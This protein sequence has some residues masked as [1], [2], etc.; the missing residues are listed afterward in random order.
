MTT[1][2]EA[3]TVFEGL[4]L[5]CPL[6]RM[7]ALVEF[8]ATLLGSARFKDMLEHFSSVSSG[9]MFLLS[10]KRQQNSWLETLFLKP[11][12]PL[13][14]IFLNWTTKGQTQIQVELRNETSFLNYIFLF[15][16]CPGSFQQ[17]QLILKSKHAAA[18]QSNTSTLT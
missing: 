13:E 15:Q 10:L 16:K 11:K 18:F 1:T 4:N 9:F 12:P 2:K 14:L 6:T 5:N 7:S 8:F 17:Q 3:R